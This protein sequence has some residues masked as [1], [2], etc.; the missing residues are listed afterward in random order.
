[1]SNLTNSSFVI[2]RIKSETS[3]AWTPSP[4]PPF[5]PV[6]IQQ[7][8]E[9]L[10][11]FFL[12]IVWSS[13]HQQEMAGQ[14]GQGLSQAIP[15]GVPGLST[16][17]GRRHF[18]SFVAYDQVPTT[19]GST[20]FGLDIFIAGE[21]VQS[22]YYQVILKEPITRPGCLQFLVGQNLKG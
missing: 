5:E 22:P 15:L 19:I 16:E 10:K 17:E 18:V 13:R 12:P 6:S 4:E 7:R 21:F 20:Q 14:V 8:H 1:M 3:D 9:K 2:R 11:I